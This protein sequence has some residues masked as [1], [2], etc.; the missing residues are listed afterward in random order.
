[1]VGLR[2]H[3]SSP[4]I[5]VFIIAHYFLLFIFELR[6]QGPLRSTDITEVWHGPLILAAEERK[7]WKFQQLTGGL[8]PEHKEAS[9]SCKVFLLLTCFRMTPP[10][11]Q[12]KSLSSSLQWPEVHTSVGNPKG[13]Q[14]SCLHGANRIQWNVVLPRARRTGQQT[15]VSTRSTYLEALSLWKVS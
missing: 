14:P 12:E 6:W 2:S 4:K 11:H 10:W 9:L 5:Y 8:F 13:M 1:M 3:P 7:T 15:K